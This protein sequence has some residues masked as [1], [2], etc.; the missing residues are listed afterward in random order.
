MVV[1]TYLETKVIKLR[2]PHNG[3]YFYCKHLHR[4]NCACFDVLKI[5]DESEGGPAPFRIRVKNVLAELYV[6]K[7]DSI[8]K[9]TKFT[10]SQ[11]YFILEQ[12]STCFG[13]YFHHQE[14][15]TAHTAS[16]TCHT[17]LCGCLLASSHRTCMV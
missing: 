11:I 1:T 10:I 17:G 3:I 8:G 9:A 2:I 15:K 6:R 14:S 16:G 7:Y 5:T 4:I 13:W 12:H